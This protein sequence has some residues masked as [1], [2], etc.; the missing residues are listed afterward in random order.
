MSAGRKREPPV[1]TRAA[2]VWEQQHPGQCV[3]AMRHMMVTPISPP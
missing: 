2:V 1:N 3:H